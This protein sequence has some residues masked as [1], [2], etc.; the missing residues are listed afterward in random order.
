MDFNWENIV[1]SAVRNAG[2]FNNL[3]TGGS[4]YRFIVAELCGVG[5]T[6]AMELCERFGVNPHAILPPS[7]IEH[8]AA[9]CWKAMSD[10]TRSRDEILVK[11]WNLIEE[12]AD[13]KL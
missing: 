7:D 10:E 8:L 13:P 11:A 12:A 1:R 6:S 5:S 4:P 2:M 3:H 9:E